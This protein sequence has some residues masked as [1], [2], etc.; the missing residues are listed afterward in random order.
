MMKN[1]PL[2]KKPAIAVKEIQD[3]YARKNFENLQQYFAT[4]NQLQGFK[5]FELVFTKAET[6]KKFAHGLTIT[7]RDLIVTSVTG[8]G[9]VQFNT[10]LFDK[11]NL[12]ISTTGAVTVRF[13]IG[14]YWNSPN[15]T[16]TLVRK[17]HEHALGLW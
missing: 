14:S 5:F 7:P 9:T 1:N 4:E 6:N 12:D 10:G 13:Y 8:S 3:I 2:A 15:N 17:A 16:R 11:T